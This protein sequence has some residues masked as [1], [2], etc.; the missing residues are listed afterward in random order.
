MLTTD[1]K[2][3]KFEI[4]PLLNE[5]WSPRMFS[6]Q[7]VSETELRT[8]FEAGRWAPSSNNIQPWR[9]V[10][11]IKG[12]KTYA[13]IFECLDDFNQK[14]AGNAPVLLL[15]AF[16]KTNRDGKENFHALHDL[17]AFSA[18]MT[19][20]AQHLGIAVHQMAGIKY[21]KAKTEFNFPDDYH[22]AT[23]IAMGYYG[24]DTSELPDELEKIETSKS[25]RLLQREFTFN[26]DFSE[27]TG[28]SSERQPLD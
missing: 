25:E 15:G 28:M 6:E 2:T 5:R 16:K 19:V 9:I 8:I 11:G 26:G 27:T 23:G 1:K 7:T 24:G 10:W 22:V 20:Q 12:S 13:R 18:M 17:G 4:H 21:E 3:T 14:W